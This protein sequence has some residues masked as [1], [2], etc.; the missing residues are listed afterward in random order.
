M[1]EIGVFEKIE[2]VRQKTR[3][4]GEDYDGAP[5]SY[6][7]YKKMLYI[8]FPTHKFFSDLDK[9]VALMG[10]MEKPMPFLCSRLELL[11]LILS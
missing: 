2:F 7:D 4:L 10:Y 5:E 8:A 1:K 6:E 11:A 3:F 9:I